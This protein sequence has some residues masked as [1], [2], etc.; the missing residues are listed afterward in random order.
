MMNKSLQVV[1]IKDEYYVD[2]LDLKVIIT[3]T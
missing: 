2:V 1:N 3:L